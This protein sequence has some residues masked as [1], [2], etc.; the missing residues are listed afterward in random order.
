MT[1][2]DSTK[3]IEINSLPLFSIYFSED[4]YLNITVEILPVVKPQSTSHNVII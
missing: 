1:Y 3:D 2:Y 4:L